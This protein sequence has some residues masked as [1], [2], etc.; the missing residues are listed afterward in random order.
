MEVEP[1]NFINPSIQ[2]SPILQV[3]HYLEGFHIT[4][5]LDLGFCHANSAAIL[6][7]VS[8]LVCV[9]TYLIRQCLFE[10]HDLLW[11]LV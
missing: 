7:P 2:L 4:S 8:L 5:F 1:M 10:I 6:L 9:V 3:A 11:N